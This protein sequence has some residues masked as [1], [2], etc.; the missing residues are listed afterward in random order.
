MTQTK[1]A[2]S[3]G[4]AD[5]DRLLGGGIFVG[6][7]VVWYDDAGSLA[8]PF[9]LAFIRHSLAEEKALIYVSFDRSVR[10]LLELLGPLAE[11]PSLTVID[12][13]TH[14]KGEGAEIFLDFY[15]A[16]PPGMSGR[17][18]RLPDPRDTEA[19]SAALYRVHRERS[20]DVRFVFDSLTGMQALW[21][22]EEAILQ[23]YSRACPRLYELNTIAYWIIEKGA[24]SARLRANLN[25]I[26]QVAVD[27]S[28]RRGKTALT[29]LKAA[30]HD[31][32][33][34][35]TPQPY[36]TEGRQITIDAESRTP[37]GIDLGSR[38]RTLRTRRGLSQTE[39]ARSVGVTP[40][41][42]SQVEHNQIYPSLPALYKMSETLGVEVGALFDRSGRPRRPVVFAANQ[43]TA[44]APPAGWPRNAVAI[45]RLV[46]PGVEV[47]VEPFRVEIP[48]GARLGGHFFQH[49]GGEVGFLEAGELVLRMPDGP[50]PVRAGD[51]V[52]LRRE[53]PVGWENPGSET[54]R[55]FWLKLP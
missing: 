38:I 17:V 50:Q 22:S 33:R 14:G 19:V 44:V 35:N 30:M 8:P 55:L 24:H 13:F 1:T 15:E 7:N 16:P 11:S 45:Q 40:S 54:A 27:L 42:I 25:Q 47:E 51:T 49:K 52:Y 10:H 41:T 39:L 48:G 43:A 26:T 18:V 23:F 20:G 34:L 46:P 9:C 6:D 28:V 32:E 12:G 53:V 31:T 36:W 29:V 4:V 21:G 37:G 3:S 2:V 5:L